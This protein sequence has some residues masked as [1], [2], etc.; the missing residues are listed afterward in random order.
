MT[1][2]VASL[3][4][5]AELD[6]R[7]EDDIQIQLSCC[8]NRKFQQCVLNNAKHQCKAVDNFKKLQRANSNSSQRMA[9]KSLQRVM[10]SMMDDLKSTLESMSLTGPEL[11]C[12]TVDDNFC[13]TKFEGKFNHRVARHKSIVPAMIKIYSN[14]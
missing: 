1:N 5:I 10:A 14:K 6:R 2:Y 7:S 4:G 3:E 11:I 8:A 12:R 13:K 9:H